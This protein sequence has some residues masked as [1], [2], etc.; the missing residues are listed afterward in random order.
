MRA[1]GPLFAIV[2]GT[3]VGFGWV[4]DRGLDGQMRRAHQDGREAAEESARLTA[5][6]VRATVLAVEQQVLARDPVAGAAVERLAIEPGRTVP[7]SGTV[8]YA[9]R[10]RS[11]LA[12]LL[13][14]TESSPSGLP[15][16]VMARLA[17]GEA[18]SASVPGEPPPPDVPTLLLSGELPVRP[19]DLPFLAAALGVADDPRVASLQARLRAAPPAAA[20]PHA[21]ETGRVVRDGRLV[22]TTVHERHRVRYELD[23]AWLLAK[24]RVA[25][26]AGASMARA[27]GADAALAVVADVEGLSILVPVRVPEAFRLRALRTGL[28]LAVAASIG[29]LLVVRRALTAEAKATAREKSFLASV[30]H[31]LRTPLAAIRLLGERLAQGRGNPQEYGALVAEETERLESLV[32]RVLAA[33][34]ASERPSFAPVEPEALLRSAVDLI[35]PRAERRDVTLTCRAAEPLPAATWDGEAVRRAVLNLLDNAIKHGREGGTVEAGARA[36]GE[37]ICLSVADDGPGIGPRDRKD[38]FGRFV[39]G[40]TDASGTGL[41]LHFAE[42]VAHAHGGRVDLVSEEGRGCVFTLRLPANPALHPGGRSVS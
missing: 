28:W 2:A 42:Q 9:R 26:G 17:L 6:S 37:D 20:L 18:A 14:S 5:A 32:E 12:R 23:V 31:E 15:E 11:E 25:E 7:S 19:D 8:P 29:C 1:A 36:E 40:R 35:R 38:L 41:G 4:A 3:F 16:A 33:T 30:T 21:P 27:A 39:R 10:S 13:R 22:G 24:A 34:R